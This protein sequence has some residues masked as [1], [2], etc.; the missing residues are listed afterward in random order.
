MIQFQTAVPNVPKI[1][2]A[3]AMVAQPARLVTKLGKDKAS[4]VTTVVKTVS[5]K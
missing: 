2:L 4:T 1:S 5:S 3:L